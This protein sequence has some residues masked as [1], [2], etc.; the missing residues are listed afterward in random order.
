MM[1]TIAKKVAQ[2]VGVSCLYVVTLFTAIRLELLYLT[3]L[4]GFPAYVTCWLTGYWSGPGSVS[5]AILVSAALAG[6]L[7]IPASLLKRWPA[8]IAAFIAMLLL[9]S[10]LGRA[11][12]KARSRQ[13]KAAMEEPDR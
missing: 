2:G 3:A 7:W 11:S 9:M 13:T 10:A 1:R 12:Y 4:L 6:L 5:Y 8:R